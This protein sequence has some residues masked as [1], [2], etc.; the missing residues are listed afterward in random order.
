MTVPRTLAVADRDRALQIRFSEDADL[1]PAQTEA[2][3]SEFRAKE[4][5]EGAR[6]TAPAPARLSRTV[7]A[8]P[9][10]VSVQVVLRHKP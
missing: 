8:E 4:S 9:P 6:M 5:E 10:S 2:V 1:Q 7:A 3:R